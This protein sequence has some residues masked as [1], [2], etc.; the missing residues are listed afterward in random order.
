MTQLSIPIEYDLTKEVK[1]LEYA[2]NEQRKPKDRYVITMYTQINNEYLIICARHI[3]EK[4]FELF[5][6]L[7]INGKTP[8]GFSA[9][10]RHVQ[11]IIK[12]FKEISKPLHLQQKTLHR[13][14]LNT[15]TL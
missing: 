12:D 10:W 1:S 2:L 6:V 9:N 14:D 4:Y 13:L 8:N 3:N 5:N 11:H 7:D 15:S